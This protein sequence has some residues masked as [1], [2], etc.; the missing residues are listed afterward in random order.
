M[1]PN[2][3]EAVKMDA[4]RS[5]R[6]FA[7]SAPKYST[8]IAF[9]SAMRGI[10]IMTPVSPSIEKPTAMK[11]QL[12]DNI[13]YSEGPHNRQANNELAEAVMMMTLLSSLEKKLKKT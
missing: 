9:C 4:F 2:A 11:T 13:S 12:S 3:Y 8:V 7:F 6:L 10:P 5:E 1:S